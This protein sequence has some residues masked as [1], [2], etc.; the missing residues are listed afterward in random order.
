MTET[1]IA[2]AGRIAARIATIALVLAGVAVKLSVDKA[3]AQLAEAQ[4]ELSR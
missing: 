2:K 3:L 4:R 1:P